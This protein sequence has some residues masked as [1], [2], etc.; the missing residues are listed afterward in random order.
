[1]ERL[2]ERNTPVAIAQCLASARRMRRAKPI[3]LV[4]ATRARQRLPDHRAASEPPS[5]PITRRGKLRR[6]LTWRAETID[7]D[8]LVGE[9]YHSR[10]YHWILGV[11]ISSSNRRMASNGLVPVVE[12]CGLAGVLRSVLA[13][14][15]TAECGRV[16]LSEGAAICAE[17]LH[18]LVS[19]LRFWWPITPKRGDSDFRRDLASIAGW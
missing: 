9:N 10:L 6:W 7:A 11:R 2:E 13:R 16:A 17:Y 1:M 19:L 18:S 3:A 15:G 14:I 4:S 5:G 8:E 12:L